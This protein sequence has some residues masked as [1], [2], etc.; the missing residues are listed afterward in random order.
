MLVL[1]HHLLRFFIILLRLI[2]LLLLI[3][4]LRL[5]SFDTI[6]DLFYECV[7]SKL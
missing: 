7:V 6:C 2:I 1:E 4:L 3:I 5:I